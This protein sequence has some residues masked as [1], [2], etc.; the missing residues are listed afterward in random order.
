[1]K[2]VHCCLKRVATDG[3]GTCGLEPEVAKQVPS[4]H[5]DASNGLREP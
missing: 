2:S 4:E 1:M 5:I 3:V